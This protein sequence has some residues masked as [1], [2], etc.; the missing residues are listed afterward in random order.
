MENYSKDLYNWAEALGNVHIPRWEELPQLSL[1]MDQ[2]LFY[3]NDTLSFL[4]VSTSKDDKKKDDKLLTSAMI[5][6][7]VKQHFVT[8]PNKKRYEK[9]Q[10]ASLICF[11][12]L[13]PV[14][15]LGEIRK[16]LE[17]QLAFCE[18][19]AEA[20]YNMFCEQVEMALRSVAALICGKTFDQSLYTETA[21]DI[22]GMNMA[23]LSLA[24]K[25]VAQKV[26]AFREENTQE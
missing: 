18:G 20:A 4:N 12:L 7:Y 19:G 16:G 26:L 3:I 23:A 24:T 10:I 21:T 8:K 13:K 5:N 25:L 14:L 1:Y 15:Q 22:C 17:H 11:V 2:V 9:E 6:N